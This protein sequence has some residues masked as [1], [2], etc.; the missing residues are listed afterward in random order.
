MLIVILI[1]IIYCAYCQEVFCYILSCGIFLL[2]FSFERSNYNHRVN[3]RVNLETIS[4]LV[5]KSMSE[6]NPIRCAM[7]RNYVVNEARVIKSKDKTFTFDENDNTVSGDDG[8]IL[9]SSV[10]SDFLYVTNRILKDKL[11]EL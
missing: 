7:I 9:V 6:N 3:D 1:S 11:N 5:C 4:K 10:L 8:L 2:Y